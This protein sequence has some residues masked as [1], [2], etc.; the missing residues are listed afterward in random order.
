MPFSD[1]PKTTSFGRVNMPGRSV[2][3]SKLITQNTLL[4]SLL[5]YLNKQV[6]IRTNKYKIHHDYRKKL[7]SLFKKVR[8]TV[9]PPIEV[10]IHYSVGGH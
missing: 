1:P 6:H 7:N 3:G 9:S 5:M 8:P 4:K 2:I 10:N